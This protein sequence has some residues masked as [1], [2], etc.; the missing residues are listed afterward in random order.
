MSDE[1]EVVSSEDA[2]GRGLVKAGW[3][4]LLIWI[5]AALLLHLGWGVGLIGA[6]AIVLATQAAR[7]YRGLQ[8][9]R[10]GIAAGVILVVCGVW[11]VFDVSAPLVPLLCI[12]AGI[13]LLV[14]T[15]AAKRRPHA[16]QGQP[17]LH[18]AAHQR[19]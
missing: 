7:R 8:W 10:F 12:G 9:D 3:G 2:S 16:P 5:G 17:D 14:S 15:W 11:N 6:G 1:R 4:L 13:A 18:A 19:K